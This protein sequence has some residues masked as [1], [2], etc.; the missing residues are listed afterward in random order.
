[1]R[2]DILYTVQYVDSSQNII[3]TLIAAVGRSWVGLTLRYARLINLQGDYKNDTGLS[4]WCRD[5]ATESVLL[6]VPNV[7]TYIMCYIR[8]K[9]NDILSMFIKF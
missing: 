8:Q 9:A 1:M 6:S 5:H 4:V 2:D 7:T 3:Q